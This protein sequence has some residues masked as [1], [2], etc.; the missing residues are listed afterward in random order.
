MTET[1]TPAAD[2][3]RRARLAE[4]VAERDEVAAE[5][6]L[7]PVGGDMADRTQN[8]DALIRLATLDQHIEELQV[9]LQETIVAGGSAADVAAIGS[10]VWLRFED[11]VD[12]EEVDPGGG[13]RKDGS[14][15]YV[16]GLAEQARGNENIITP[17]S[18]LGRAVLDARADERVTYAGPR[19]QRVTVTVTAVD[20]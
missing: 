2:A 14:Q 19:G 5:A 7:P 1:T 11:G 3:A 9:Q 12:R 15:P 17:G 6:A 10:T 18:P 20:R 4:L 8:I 16:I 13:D